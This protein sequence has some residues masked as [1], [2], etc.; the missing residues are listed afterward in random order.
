MGERGPKQKFTDISCPN[1]KCRKYGR[2][3]GDNI[4]ANGTYET[5]SGVVRK[6]ICKECGRVFNDRTGTAYQG[7][8]TTSSKFDLVMACVANGFSVRRTAHVVGCSTKT[9]VELTKKGGHHASKVSESL[10]SDGIEPVCLQF[11]EM[12]YT[13]KKR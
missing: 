9:V 4:I 3:G 2:T 11:D 5:K 10:E 12:L 7:I 13:L 1:E 8:H 6:Y